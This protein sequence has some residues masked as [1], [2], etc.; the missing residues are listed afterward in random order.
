[1]RRYYE[2]RPCH[3]LEAKT[4]VP[5]RAHTT[6]SDSLFGKFCT[7]ETALTLYAS[8]LPADQRLFAVL[9]GFSSVNFNATAVAKARELIQTR[10][11]LA[12]L[13]ELA[14]LESLKHIRLSTIY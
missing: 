14:V 3:I 11:S 9:Q 1:M 12:G 4:E 5:V 10:K 8:E 2:Y 6:A 13:I 7:P